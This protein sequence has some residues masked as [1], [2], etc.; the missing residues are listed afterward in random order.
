MEQPER[1][2]NGFVR[3]RDLALMLKAMPIRRILS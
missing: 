3:L 2:G 1:V